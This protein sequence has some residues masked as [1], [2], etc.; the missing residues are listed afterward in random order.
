MRSRRR[1]GSLVLF[2][3]IAIATIGACSLPTDHTPRAIDRSRLPEV[4]Q[5]EES[6]TTSAPA[7]NAPAA[8]L[9]LI[10]DGEVSMVERKVT[11]LSPKVLIEAIR[12]PVSKVDKESG[13]TSYVPPD[14]RVIGSSFDNHVLTVN[15][16]DE[17]NNVASPNNK[18]AYKQMVFTLVDSLPDVRRVA[19]EIDGKPTK[20]P[21]D[22]TPRDEAGRSD[23]NETPSRPTTVAPS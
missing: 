18:L 7:T 20:I 22:S 13:R 15:L 5:P 17:I 6:T 8:K 19:F 4:L 14:L 23:Y 12:A 10:D 3:A 16:T 2:A 21:T 11:N 1:A 9:W